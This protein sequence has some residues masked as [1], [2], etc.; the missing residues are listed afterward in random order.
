MKY[1]SK[2]IPNAKDRILNSTLYIIGKEGFQNVTIRKIAAAA[3]V[4]VASINYYFGSK[5]GVINEALKCLTSKF[6]SSFE[7]LEN[8]Q[9]TPIDRFRNFLRSY[10]DAS[11]EYPDVFRNFV[12]QLIIYKDD[13]KFD[14]I[15]FIEDE[16]VFKI[17]D[18]LSEVTGIKDEEKLSMMALQ[19]I[20]S[21]IFPVISDN[22][23]RKFS[24]LNYKDKNVR[25]KYIDVLIKSLQGNSI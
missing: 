16:R 5:E 17:K 1:N 10:S 8:K 23:T 14:Y 4:N 6:M 15:K 18:I 22:Q 19:G 21:L 25:H 3:D 12:N 9:I 7:I 11:V 20:A 24:N 2:D 13:L